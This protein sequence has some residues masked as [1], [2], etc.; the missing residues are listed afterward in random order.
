VLKNPVD[1]KEGADHDDF[2]ENKSFQYSGE[3]ILQC[4]AML[5][6]DQSPVKQ[7]GTEKEGQV[8]YI[9]PIFGK[10]MEIFLLEGDSVHIPL[11]I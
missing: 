3:I 8:Y 4:D 11:I 2:G 5:C 9:D 10:F 7:H 1:A 6:K